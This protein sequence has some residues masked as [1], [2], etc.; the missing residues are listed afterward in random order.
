MA[1]QHSSHTPLPHV[2]RRSLVPGAAVSIVVAAVGIVLLQASLAAG[3]VVR[4]EAEAGR[5]GNALAIDDAS[6]SGGRAIVFGVAA[7][8]GGSDGPG[9]GNSAGGCVAPIN[10][11]ILDSLPGEGIGWQR[12]SSGKADIP[13]STAGL[14]AAWAKRVQ[15]A[16]G[17]WNVSPCLNTTATTAPCNDERGCV[18]VFASQECSGDTLGT[19]D[20]SV[21]NQFISGGRLELCTAAHEGF[22]ENEALATVVHEMGHNLGLSHRETPGLMMSATGNGDTDPK[23]DETDLHNIL[24]IYGNQ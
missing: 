6:A 21:S 9:A 18:R 14:D 16:V 2:R 11:T 22:G 3:P 10:N 13:F 23:P 4:V 20:W 17:I 24:V 5:G 8:P 1:P 12:G 19:A 15:Q 7:G